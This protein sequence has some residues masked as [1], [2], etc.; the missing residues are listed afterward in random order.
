[1]IYL[2]DLPSKLKKMKLI[3]LSTIF[4]LINS[5]KGFSQ[6]DTLFVAKLAD[7]E[8]SSKYRN[9]DNFKAI[10]FEDGSI[11]GIGDTMKIGVPSGTNIT[12]TTSTGIVGSSA[13]NHNQFTFMTFGRMG[14]Q[15]MGGVS[16]LPE[17]FKLG[18]YP[19][20]EIKIMH[21]GL[22]KKSLA[23]PYII[24]SNKGMDITTYQLAKALETGELINLKQAMTR[25]QAIA[26]LK[27]S[28]ELLELGIIS[29][30]DYEKTKEDLSKII[31]KK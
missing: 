29:K 8:Y 7:I 22:S 1:M 24:F 2:L 20:E 15:M 31:M 16:Y 21:N 6:T 4:L 12:R 14:M 30:E 11:L 25:E 28:K 13:S 19:I 17:S 27:E 23:V 5:L 10:Q 9:S 26:K 3:Y 18:L